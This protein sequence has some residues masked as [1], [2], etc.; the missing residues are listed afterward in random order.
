MKKVSFVLLLLFVFA[1]LFAQEVVKPGMGQKIDNYLQKAINNGWTGSV[2]VAQKGDI[3]IA[4]GYGFADKES[5]RLQ[6]S[7]TVFS[8]GSITKQFTGA[9]ILK[10]ETQ[11]KLSTNDLITKYF[12]DVPDDKKNI[13]LHQLLTHSAGFRGA[14]GGD[15]DTIRAEDFIKLAMNAPLLFK[16]GERYEYS[17]VGY[18]LLGIIIEQVSGKNYETYLYDNIFKPAGMEKTG[19]LRPKFNKEQLA[20]GYRQ[21]N[22]WGTALDRPWRED[23]PGWH[24]RANGGILSTVDDMHKWALALKNN[25]VLS[26]AAKEK[27]FTPHIKEYEDGNS[28]YGYGWVNQKSPYNTTQIWHNGGNGVYNAFMGMDLDEDITIIISSNIAG[29]ISDDLAIRINDILHGQFQE[30]DAK[31]IAQYQG[32]YQLASGSKIQ[33]HFNENNELITTFEGADAAKLLIGNDDNEESCKIC[34][35]YD[36]RTKDILEKVLNNDFSALAKAWGEPLDEVQERAAPFWNAQ[37]EMF[38]KVNTIESLGTF[39][40]P[41]TWISF[42]K[43]QFEKQP[44]FLMYIWENDQL[45]GVRDMPIMDKIFEM[46]SDTTFFSPSNSKTLIFEKSKN[47]KMQIKI[48]NNERS[49]VAEKVE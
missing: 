7:E 21:G 12:K 14:M 45:M 25:T 13:T 27:Y 15:Y 18:S 33:I 36:N 43:I 11:G 8:I 16:P 31:L 2:L 24:L 19:Y 26:A 6:T 22:R 44:L 48:G 28:Y 46:Q 32:V 10:L 40:R 39:K 3:I 38:G 23:G 49:I 30:L 4:K 29:K 37:K 1:S 5:K 42:A 35:E 34:K 47:G 9:A 17:N 20:V 41:Q